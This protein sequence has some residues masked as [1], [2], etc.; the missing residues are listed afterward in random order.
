VAH[1]VRDLRHHHG[2]AHRQQEHRVSSVAARSPEMFTC[3]RMSSVSDRG[4]GFGVDMMRLFARAM[5]MAS[6][7]AALGMH[8]SPPCERGFPVE[9][10]SS[11][12]RGS[13]QR[14]SIRTSS[15][16]ITGIAPC[17]LVVASRRPRARAGDWR[18]HRQRRGRKA[19][20]PESRG[21]SP[22]WQRGSTHQ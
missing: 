2:E 6:A 18:R 14:A 13:H 22:K 15:N 11:G 4:F 5:A 3:E 20:P 9:S 12:G 16:A 7:S 10:P 1:S 8:K 19:P 21:C 17:G